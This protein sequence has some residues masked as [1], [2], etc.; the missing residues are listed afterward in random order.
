MPFKLPTLITFIKRRLTNKKP[1]TP[2][3][4]K[5]QD[6]KEPKLEKFTHNPIMKPNPDNN[7]ESKAVFNSAA[8]Y[9]NGKV[10][11]A[12]R[13]I[14][15]DDISSIGYAASPDGLTIDERLEK[16]MYVPRESF[17]G[18]SETKKEFP[19]PSPYVSGGGGW[20]GCEDPRLT[21]FDDRVYM[22]Y[23]AFNGWDSVRIALTSISLNDFLNKNWK[24]DSPVPIS[25]PG[26]IDK[27]GCMLPEKINGKYVIFH[28]I[29]PNILIDFVESLNFDGRTKWLKGE[30]KIKPRKTFW[31]S[32]K[33]GVGAPPI[34]TKYGWLLI[35]HGVGEKDPSRYKIGAM[36]LDLKNP[37]RVIARCKKPILE[38]DKWYENEGFK[39][40]V[41]YPCGAIVIK[42]TLLVYYGGADMVVCVA[43]AK[44]DD[45]VNQL[46]STKEPTLGKV[47]A[48]RYVNK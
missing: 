5:K 9:E 42:D 16:P 6:K 43:T 30:Y 34:K 22:T 40:G 11:L 33:I 35:Y 24:W 37:T 26:V 32:R 13:A 39:F 19:I 46:L 44:L 10:H 28:R 36:L 45:F 27:N 2:L 18:K 3:V 31:D 17:E 25:P 8:L 41:I 14:G 1:L 20:G 38:P 23:V 29:F 4:S 12:Y 7:W 21:K 15:N 47:T 48:A